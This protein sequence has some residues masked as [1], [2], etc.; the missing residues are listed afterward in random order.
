[1]ATTRLMTVD[2]LEALPDDGHVWELIDGELQRREPMGGRHADLGAGVLA[3]IWWFLREHPL[4]R[5]LNAEA[6]YLLQR[7]PQLAV[8]PDVSFVREDRLPAG[9]LYDKPLELV[10]DLVVEVV[11]PNDR[12]GNVERQIQRYLRFGVPLLWVFW[13][14]RRAIAVYADG[15]LVRELGEGDELD[16]G[17]VLPGFHVPVA[18]LFDIGR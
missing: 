3:R 16:G 8:K 6:I 10:P 7:D 1:M 2:D 12:A 17:D 14:R 5:A 15:R 13:P 18:E 11:S 4:G 9:D